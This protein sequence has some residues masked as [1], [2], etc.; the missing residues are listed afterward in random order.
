MLQRTHGAA[1]VLA[2]EWVLHV[3]GVPLLSW[4][5]AGALLIGCCAGPLADVD[6]PGSVIAK[7]LFPLSALLKLLRV[8]H[9]TLTH[10]FVMLGLLYAATQPLPPVYRWTALLAYATHPLLDLFNE[11]GVALFWPMRQKVRL[12][13]RFMAVDTG[14]SV[15]TLLCTALIAACFWLPLRTLLGF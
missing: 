8:Q 11:K 6:K 7:L 15:E 1:G 12:L 14:G 9:R 13:P 5:T 4:E 3:H 10:S 2:A